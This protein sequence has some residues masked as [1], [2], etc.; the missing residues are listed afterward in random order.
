MIEKYMYIDY[1]SSGE[2]KPDAKY[3][4]SVL[5]V[6]GNTWHIMQAVDGDIKYAKLLLENLCFNLG[7]DY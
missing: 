5:P 1:E 2:S 6:G 7:I 3:G 4:G